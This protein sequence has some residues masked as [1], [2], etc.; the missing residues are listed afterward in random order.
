METTLG[1][2]EV[3][4]SI[5]PRGTSFHKIHNCQSERDSRTAA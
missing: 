3:G 1:K 5:L 2:G 4:S